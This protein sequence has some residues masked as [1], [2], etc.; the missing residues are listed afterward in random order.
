MTTITPNF[1]PTGMVFLKV[2][3]LIRARVGGDVVILRLASEQKNPRT[4]PPTQKRGEAGG[5]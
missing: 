5:L 3:D 4:Q 2:F 1:F